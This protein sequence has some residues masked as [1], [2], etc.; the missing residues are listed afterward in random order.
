MTAL[1][2]VIVPLVIS[3]NVTTTV[4]N[5]D[6]FKFFITNTDLYNS[7]NIYVILLAI[8]LNSVVAI[9]IYII[10]IKLNKFFKNVIDNNPFNEVN[11]HYLKAIGLI[12]VFCVVIYFTTTSIITQNQAVEKLSLI[13]NI[14]TRVMSLI[15]VI[16]NPFFLIGSFIYVLGEI[17]VH[18]SKLKQES[19]LTV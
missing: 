17:V 9:G 14:L 3:I 13:L 11:G 16:F 8:A 10:L 4:S 18:A 5:F 12:G 1:L 19:D 15:A 2:F 7:E 6:Y